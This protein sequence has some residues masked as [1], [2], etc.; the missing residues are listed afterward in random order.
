MA[1][2]AGRKKRGKSSEGRPVFI[3]LSFVII[4]VAIAFS[5]S[6]FFR[7][8]D[9][10]VVG[11]EYY[12][13]EEIIEASGIE[14]G[15]SLISLSSAKVEERI[16]GVLLFA[17][18]AD[19]SKKIPGTVL[20]TISESGAAAAVNTDEGIWLIDNYC[21]LLEPA[22]G[23]ERNKYIEVIGVSALSPKAGGELTV[24]AEDKHKGT[25]LKEIIFALSEAE[26]LGDV[27]SINVSNTAN[28][29]FRYL[30]RFTVKL[31]PNENIGAKLEMLK[32]AAAEIKPAESG[33]F[34]L[35]ES[36]KASFKPEE[37]TEQE[38]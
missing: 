22:K 21:R 34:D 7:V 24:A 35:S 1:A 17:G 37:R 36:K 12:S 6:I 32:S 14:K 30:E 29:E 15:D 19:V 4:C 16:S 10:E 18:K 20:I 25:Y 5:I 13:P 23:A 8:S 11:A 3:V 38:K 31:G 27:E 26:M 33:V 2:H 28:A 9:I